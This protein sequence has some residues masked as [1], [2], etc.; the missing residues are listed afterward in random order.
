M[1]RL[2]DLSGKGKILIAVLVVLLLALV[3][4][5]VYNFTRSSDEGKRD[6]N[7]KATEATPIPDED[8]IEYHY[9]Q[10][11]QARDVSMLEQLMYECELCATTGAEGTFTI[12]V[13]NGAVSISFTGSGVG[14]GWVQ[15]M[16]DQNTM[17]L[18]SET[19]GKIKDGV[20]SG[21]AENAVVTWTQT[22]VKVIIENSALMSNRIG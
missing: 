10:A 6:K 22:N 3:G 1:K 7:D 13:S 19:F 2:A 4:G 9:E 15:K 21:V 12:G 8:S 11:L 18:M 20:F 14:E 17:T 16:Y 5:L